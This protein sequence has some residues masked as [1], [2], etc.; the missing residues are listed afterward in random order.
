[1]ADVALDRLLREVEAVTDLTVDEPLR[2]Q[3]E[4]LDLARSRKV[5]RLRAGRAR[6]ELDQVD[7]RVPPSRYRL[8]PAGVLAVPGENLFAL[9]CVHEAGIGAS[10]R[11]L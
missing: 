6:R 1:M 3:L 8:E 7:H 2:D 11:P 9:C 10:R 4:H 5:L